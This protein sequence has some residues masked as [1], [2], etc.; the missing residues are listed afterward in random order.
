FD[1]LGQ[2]IKTYGVQTL[3]VTASLFNTLIDTAPE[4]LEGVE[5][6]LSGGEALSVGHVRRA[7]ELLPSTRLINGYGPS[8]CTVFATAY[9]I[10]RPVEAACSTIPLGRPIGDRSV[11]LVDRWM[12]L[13]PLGVTGEIV[14]GGPA[15]ARGYLGQAALT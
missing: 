1:E 10:E 3:W 4:T 15:L 14:I 8:E 13:V 5:Q 6:I 12:G 2:L 11:Y 7:L 9:V